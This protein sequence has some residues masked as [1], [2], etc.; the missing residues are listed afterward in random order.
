ML[1]TDLCLIQSRRCHARICACLCFVNDTPLYSNTR[2]DFISRWY[3]Y[4]QCLFCP[5]LTIDLVP[6]NCK[7]GNAFIFSGMK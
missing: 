2:W 6:V 3:S 1:R 7:N 4:K 5:D